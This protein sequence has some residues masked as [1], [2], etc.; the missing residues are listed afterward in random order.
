MEY[1]HVWLDSW[2]LRVSSALTAS[3]TLGLVTL[4]ALKS[5]GKREEKEMRN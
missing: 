2:W 1:S 4:E 5:K 3:L